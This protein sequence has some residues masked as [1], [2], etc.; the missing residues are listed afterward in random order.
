MD[1]TVDLIATCSFAVDFIVRRDMVSLLGIA[2]LW[3]SAIIPTTMVIMS[4]NTQIWVGKLL[5]INTL[6][7]LNCCYKVLQDTTTWWWSAYLFVVVS[8]LLFKLLTMALYTL[9]IQC[10]ATLVMQVA[11]ALTRYG[12]WW[13]TMMTDYQAFME[14]YQEQ[15]RHRHAQQQEQN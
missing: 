9:V 7:C 10:G 3:L 12:E 14:K 6:L 15:Q 13:N 4:P 5:W 2:T 11:I 1:H 8:V